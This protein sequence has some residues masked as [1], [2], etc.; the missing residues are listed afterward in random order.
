MGARL[1]F[2][3]VQHRETTLA[4]LNTLRKGGQ[5]CDVILEVGCRE[6]PA[7]RAVLACA[8]GYLFELFSNEEGSKLDHFK[9]PGLDF[10]S[11]NILVNYAYTSK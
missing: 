9:L 3:D 5:F 6:I 2:D 10:D 7:H 8:S 1:I 4:R 11:F